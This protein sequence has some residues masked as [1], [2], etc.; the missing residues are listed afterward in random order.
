MKNLAARLPPFRLR[1]SAGFAVLI[2]V[3]YFYDNDGILAA[4]FPA[5]IIHELGHIAA[6][7]ALGSPPRALN[8]GLAGFSL[9]YS[10][11]LSGGGEMI[12]ALAGPFAGLFFAWLCAVLGARIESRYLLLCAGLGFA[13]NAF[14]LIPALPLDGGRVLFAALTLRVSPQ[15]A[16]RIMLILGI[17][18]GLILTVFGVFFLVNGQGIALIP[19]GLWLLLSQ[20]KSFR[21]SAFLP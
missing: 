16:A 3:V 6:L 5:V 2:S 15:T 12:S 4:M 14:N 18:L 8:A 11:E 17:C 20:H 7:F 9:D 13:I 10:E 21:N 19:A 1:F